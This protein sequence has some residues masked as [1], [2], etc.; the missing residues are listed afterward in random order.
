MF[1]NIVSKIV[2]IVWSPVLVAVCI[3]AGLL[4]SILTRF[5]QV[6]KFKEMFRLLFFK[7]KNKKI[8]ISS[9]QAFALAIS[10]RVGTGNIAGVATAIALGG[11]GSIF[12]MW[13]I[14]FFGS[15]TAF[16]ESTL[17][18]IFKE[19]RDNQ[20]RG[21]PSYFIK[22]GLNC[23][24]LAVAFAI[25]TILACGFLLPTVQSNSVSVAMHNSFGINKLIVGV[26]LATF[27]AIVIIGGV[28]RI[29]SV[30]EIVAPFMAI[31][32]IIV[33][34][35][36]LIV[37]IKAVP[38]M[39]GLIFESAFGA[40][41]VFGAIIGSTI[42]MGVKRG[43]FSNEAGQGSGAIIAAA[44]KVSHPVKQGL[45]QSF[46]VYVDTF[47]VCTATAIMI[48]STGMYNVYDGAGNC[49]MENAGHLKENVYF[50]QAAV[51]TVFPGIGNIFI[52]LSLLFFVFTTLMA[53][54]Y[55]AET[56]L[57]YMFKKKNNEKTAIWILRLLIVIA[58]C[59]GSVRE[60]NFAW[61]LGDIGVGLMAWINIFSLFILFPIAIRTLRDYEKQQ[62]LGIEPVFDPK[63]LKIK[64]ADYW[65]KILKD[66]E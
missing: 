53:Y 25:S 14:A 38:S 65:E 57:V 4:F 16:V 36:V 34:F 2:D 49:I 24:W 56:S 58:V 46:S 18:Q 61:Q 48:L 32:Y 52:S 17:A 8:G 35:I 39:F 51:D 54:Y 33:A 55:Y 9:F 28:K 12:W 20:F 6:R 64:N 23:H 29:A 7:D 19:K 31:A 27:L 63:K 5:V 21:G 50:T 1:E 30:A 3:G 37:N 10:G 41:Q 40:H 22:K 26:F 45:V 44:A 11:P 13:I 59:Y 60:A 15:S 62:K 66:D 47:L 42:M 43:I